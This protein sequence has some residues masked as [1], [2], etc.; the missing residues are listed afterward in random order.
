MIDPF[1]EPITLHNRE[2]DAMTTTPNRQMAA[3][4]FQLSGQQLIDM[5]DSITDGLITF[6]SDW[7]F[8]FINRVAASI[9]TYPVEKLIGRRLWETFPNF[10]ATGFGQ[11]CW[12]AA[13]EGIP[14][15]H[16]DYYSPRDKWF[17][18]RAYP[19]DAGMSLYFRDTSE[20]KRAQQS[21]ATS[22]ARF[23]EL[24][25]HLH[26]L[27]GGV[28]TDGTVVSLNPAFEQIT[29]WPCDEWIGKPFLALIHPDD[30]AA[31]CAT[32]TPKATRSE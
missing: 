22:N 2:T 26:E 29:G 23:S 11:A 18:I 6:D 7:R 30:C 4:M 12:R 21:I 1:D 9:L 3:E 16:E 17:A 13:A 10:H 14:I 31:A 5:L 32:T 27:V 24:V 19:S 15:E 25:E 28:T 8:T 20:H